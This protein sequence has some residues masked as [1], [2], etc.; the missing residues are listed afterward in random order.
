MTGT[1]AGGHPSDPA[2]TENE[3]YGVQHRLQGPH[4]NSTSST[5]EVGEFSGITITNAV[6]ELADLGFVDAYEVGR[7]IGRAHV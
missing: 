2:V 3:S 7:E 1:D 6:P 4:R 5:G